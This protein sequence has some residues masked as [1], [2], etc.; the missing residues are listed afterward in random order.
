MKHIFPSAYHDFACIADRCRHSCCIGWELPVD[1]ASARRYAKIK[2][3]LGERLRSS[4]TPTGDAFLAR[5]DGRCPH[6]CEDGLCSLIV[7]VGD[8]ILPTVCQR[9]PRY[10]NAYG[11]TAR[12][13][14]LGLC[15]EEACRLLL[16]TPLSLVDGQ[17][18]EVREDS[19]PNTP[20][21]RFLTVKYHILNCILADGTSIEERIRYLGD[22]LGARIDLDLAK[23]SLLILSELERL[24]S[25]FWSKI[26]KISDFSPLCDNFSLQYTNF[27][28]L[29]FYRF[30]KFGTSLSAVFSFS[31]LLLRL[32]DAL[33]SLAPS[34]TAD[35]LLDLARALS[36]EIEYSEHNT[37][38]LVTYLEG[39]N[40]L[41]S[42]G[43]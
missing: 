9:H 32:L 8:A 10:E 33:L 27:L 24:D 43:K 1:P 7:D 20:S 38:A 18:T 15:C 35:C 22:E 34:M 28:A 4:L 25:D 31:V 29:T 13:H 21:G 17:G 37:D 26:Y 5:E 12:E 42:R 19:F 39:Q 2:G 23:A 40:F 11:I 30:A 41:F 3:E 6:L 36:C 14:G 16:L